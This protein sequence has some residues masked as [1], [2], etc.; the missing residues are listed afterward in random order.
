MAGKNRREPPSLSPAPTR[1]AVLQ[2]RVVPPPR[3]GW[4][5]TRVEALRTSA[6]ET[7]ASV[8]CSISVRNREVSILWWFPRGEVHSLRVRLGRFCVDLP[9]RGTV[10][11]NQ[12]WH[13]FLRNF[14][15]DPAS[16]TPKQKLTILRVPK[17]FFAISYLKLAGSGISLTWN[18]GSGISIIWSSGLGITLIWNSGSGISLTW[19]SWFGISLI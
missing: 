18:S 6:W 14:A 3:A 17:M 19:S 2:S 15:I 12:F 10:L 7:K 1:K 13:S 9:Y 16:L 5:G 4:V 11:V 8:V